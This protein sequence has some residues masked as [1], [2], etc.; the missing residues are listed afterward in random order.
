MDIEV[1]DEGTLV[2][3]RPRNDE[4]RAWLLGHTDGTWFVGALVVEPRY[5]AP[6]LNGA[7]A[8]GFRLRRTGGE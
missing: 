8:D 5:V 6:I 2:L 1:Q 3:L 4:A 7:I